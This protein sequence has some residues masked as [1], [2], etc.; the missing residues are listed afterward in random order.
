GQHLN[1]KYQPFRRDLD[2]VL[3]A[4]SR[5]ESKEVLYLRCK[6]RC[7]LHHHRIEPSTAPEH[8][9]MRNISNGRDALYA[10]AG[11]F[12]AITNYHEPQNIDSGLLLSRGAIIKTILESNYPLE[13]CLNTIKSESHMYGGFNLISV[14]LSDEHSKMRYLSNR[15]FGKIEHLKS[16]EI[17][18]LSNSLLD[19]P[20][21][22]VKFGNNE[23]KTI[24]EQ[25]QT[26]EQLIR[27]TTYPGE[28]SNFKMSIRIP[29]SD[30]HD[31]TRT[32]TVILVDRDDN[33][34]F[35]E[36]TWFDDDENI[37]EE[38]KCYRW[39]RFQI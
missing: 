22:K 38:D 30:N 28:N 9:N 17:Y 5:Y 29:K 36:K 13:Q 35:V 33:V 21:P 27:S 18:G 11:R 37:I 8:A 2:F 3:E 19:E 15:G 10:R 24:C 32:S 4:S 23:M 12:A 6:A 31:V 1:Q 7:P 34:V 16:G 26:E 14:D 20:W 39:F 25:E